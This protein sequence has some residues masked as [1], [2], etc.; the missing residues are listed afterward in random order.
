MSVDPDILSILTSSTATEWGTSRWSTMRYC[1]FKYELKY[2]RGLRLRKKDKESEDEEAI[3]ALLTDV[4]GSDGTPVSLPAADDAPGPAPWFATGQLVHAC[5]EWVLKGLLLGQNRPWAPV[6]DAAKGLPSHFPNT[7]PEPKERVVDEA[8]R[9]V[10][11]Y[12]GHH[13]T[14]NGGFPEDWKIIASELLL[15]EK[16]YFELPVTCRAD[17]IWQLDTG[18]ITVAD[19]KTRAKDLPKDLSKWRRDQS[20][21]PQFLHLSWQAREHFGLDYYPSIFVDTISKTSIPKARRVFVTIDPHDVIQ[22]RDNHA[23]TLRAH[24]VMLGVTG[25]RGV[26]NYNNCSPP[27]GSRCEFFGYCHG[28]TD[29]SRMLHHEF[30]AP[31]EKELTQ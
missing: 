31:K 6:I 20:V 11:A 29:E 12:Y 16:E 14:K 7:S 18:E 25:G 17:S 21:N 8:F 9:L 24:E 27:I 23:L 15:E 22:W 3:E 4:S 26:M 19:T 5:Q 30:V 13:G 1:G 2:S 10:D 28:K